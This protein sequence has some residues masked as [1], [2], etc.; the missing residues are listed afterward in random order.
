MLAL[1]L[2]FSLVS[3]QTLRG[4][5]CGAEAG[6][7]WPHLCDETT[8]VYVEARIGMS[9]MPRI[10]DV[11]QIR[12]YLELSAGIYPYGTRNI[13]LPKNQSVFQMRFQCINIPSEKSL[14]VQTRALLLALC[15]AMVLIPPTEEQ[16]RHCSPTS[17]PTSAMGPFSPKHPRST[18][19]SFRRAEHVRLR[20]W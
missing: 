2:F 12:A 8:S 6:F 9:S 5:H 18:H 15:H 17:A 16:S 10:N 20:C 13:I 7:L 14:A 1:S 3:I 19:L 11:F 4:K